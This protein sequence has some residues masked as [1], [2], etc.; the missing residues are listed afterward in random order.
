MAIINYPQTYTEFLKTIEDGNLFIELLD[1]DPEYKTFLSKLVN[2]KKTTHSDR[3]SWL[4]YCAYLMYKSLRPS[5][6]CYVG[7]TCYGSL[8]DQI[9][10]VEFKNE[11][12]Y[13]LNDYKYKCDDE[14]FTW[15]DVS[16]TVKPKIAQLLTSTTTNEY[17][18]DREKFA[19]NMFND[20][21]AEPL[22]FA[23][24]LSTLICSDYFAHGKR[25]QKWQ[26][27][28]VDLFNKLTNLFN[29]KLNKKPID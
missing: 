3:E 15:Y 29:T 6:A 23:N 7:I 20:V 13:I 8:V 21:F 1:A 25:A 9:H 14:Y 5:N 12:T 22:I 19:N 18:H 4:S 10:D 27:F 28:Y 16:D 17:I 2:I 11:M 24:K 26:H